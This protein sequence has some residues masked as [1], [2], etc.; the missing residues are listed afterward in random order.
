LHKKNNPPHTHE[1]PEIRYHIEAERSAGKGVHH[2]TEDENQG[3]PLHE[4]PV[5]PQIQDKGNQQIVKI[6][7]QKEIGQDGCLKNHKA[8]TGD[9]I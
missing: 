4:W 7:K 6:L 8:E 5:E 9:G 1:Q 2:V 3:E